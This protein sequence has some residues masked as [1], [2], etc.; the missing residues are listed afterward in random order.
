MSH[1]INPEDLQLPELVQRCEHE[2]KLYFRRQE[3]DSRYCFELFRRAIQGGDQSIW[4]S[5]YPCYSGLFRELGE[6]ASGI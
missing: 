2:T 6:A 5:I 1:E 3:H 4:E